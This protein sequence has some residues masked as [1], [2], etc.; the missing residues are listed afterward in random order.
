MLV[1]FLSADFYAAPG[2]LDPS[3]C[4]GGKVT[5]NFGNSYAGADDIA[6]QSDR[7][8]VAVGYNRIGNIYNFALARYNTNG[9][10]DT[11]FGTDGKVST[12]FAALS[13]GWA[14]VSVKAEN[15]TNCKEPS[16]MMIKRLKLAI[17]FDKGDKT[18]RLNFWDFSITA[19][20]F[21]ELRSVSAR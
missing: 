17:S 7:K 9:S 4:N 3:F 10:L 13:N 1:F 19:V 6:I 2:D 12:N 20:S 14:S 11:S 15:G 5:T 18:C 21:F 16:A 8:I